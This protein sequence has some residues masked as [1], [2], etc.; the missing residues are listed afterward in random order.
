MHSRSRSKPAMSPRKH[1]PDNHRKSSPLAGRNRLFRRR[2][3]QMADS[4]IQKPG[5]ES[6]YPALGESSG[7]PEAT[8]VVFR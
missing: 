6:A 1:T 5:L 3:A 4:I 2:V 8:A 7:V